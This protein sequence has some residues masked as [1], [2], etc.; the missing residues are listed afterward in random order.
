MRDAPRLLVKTLSVTFLTVA[1]LLVVVFI[2]VALTVREQVRASVTANLESS[3]RLFEAI[4]AAAARDDPGVALA[5]NPTLKAAL[6]TYQTE[7]RDRATN[8]SAAIC[9]RRSTTSW[10]SRRRRRVGRARPR[11]CAA[12]HDRG[13]GTLR[14]SL[15]ARQAGRLQRRR[16]RQRL[17]RDRA[18]RRLDLPRRRRAAAAR[19]RLDDRH[20]LRRDEPRSR[21]CRGTRAVCRRA[22]SSSATLRHR[23]HAAG[24]RCAIRG[25]AHRPGR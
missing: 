8:R 21:L 12:E 25:G 2:F 17:R 19:R 1:L 9:S 10:E 4:D 14:R 20:V 13:G 7:S 18:R 11:R 5:E 23:Q 15:A 16:R 22:S 6:D 3:Q 24:A